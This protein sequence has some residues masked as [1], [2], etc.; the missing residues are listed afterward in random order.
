MTENVKPKRAYRS[1][2]RAEQVA[3]NVQVRAARIQVVLVP[4]TA[5]AGDDGLRV[6]LV[7]RQTGT[8]ERAV[9]LNISAD[10]AAKLKVD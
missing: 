1:T 6:H 4:A 8:F 5:T 2:R 10:A 9:H 7:E 3:Q